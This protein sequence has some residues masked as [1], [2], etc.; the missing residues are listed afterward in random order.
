MMKV[1][2][3]E[4]DDEECYGVR[5]FKKFFRRKGKFVWQ[6][7]EERKSFQQRDDKKGKS[8]R[9]CF[10]CGDPSHLI[11]DFPKTSRNKD[12]K[13]FSLEVLGRAVCL[14]TCLERMEW[15]KDSGLTAKH[16][17]GYKEVNS[18]P[19]KHTDEESLNV[20]FDEITPPTKLSPLVDDDVDEEEAIRKNTKVLNTNNEEDELIEV[21]EIVNI[22]DSKN[23]PLDQV[24][25]ILIIT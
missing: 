8:D 13:G 20:T 1:H 7:R 15:I 5:N 21:E 24:I 6:P 16:M 14:R 12:N 18:L 22:K 2:I 23:H 4:S 10:R 9:K 11:G 17:T 25:G 3:R 19:T